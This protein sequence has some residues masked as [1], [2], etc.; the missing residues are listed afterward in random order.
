MFQPWT[1]TP[2]DL[3]SIANCC[4]VILLKSDPTFPPATPFLTGWYDRS[5]PLTISLANCHISTQD[6]SPTPA[7]P[8]SVPAY[9]GPSLPES[10]FA[11]SLPPSTLPRL[12]D[13]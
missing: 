9:R 7:S 10:D 6:H 1:G 5:C 3:G 8:V 12:T 13:S 2:P 11:T 4:V